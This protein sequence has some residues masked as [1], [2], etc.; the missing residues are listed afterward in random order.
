MVL[1]SQGRVPPSDGRCFDGTFLP[2]SES[3]LGSTDTHPVHEVPYLRCKIRILRVAGYAVSSI[4]TFVLL[5]SVLSFLLENENLEL[6][7]F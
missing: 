1:G 6:G 3:I 4:G 2:E 7:I 5:S